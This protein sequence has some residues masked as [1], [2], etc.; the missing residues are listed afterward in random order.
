MVTIIAVSLITPAEKIETLREFYRR[1]RPPGFWGPVVTE[2]S[3]VERAQIRDETLRDLIDCVLGVAFCAA[4]ILAVIAPFGGHWG[5]LAAS[6]L[7]VISCGGLFMWRWA[8]RGVFRSLGKSADEPDLHQ[9][10]N[11]FI[12]L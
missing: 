5:V 8:K 10:I 4:A 7:I 1:C 3:G 2:F 6:L 9:R 11:R 12:Q